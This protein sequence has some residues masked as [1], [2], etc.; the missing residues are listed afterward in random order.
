[1]N[2]LTVPKTVSSPPNESQPFSGRISRAA[3]LHCRRLI[4]GAILAALLFFSGQTAFAQNVTSG[5]TVYGT[6]QPAT[7]WGG[8]HDLCRG[9]AAAR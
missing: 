2:P 1:M 4:A 3:W 5:T 8:G 7:V 6:G 9:D